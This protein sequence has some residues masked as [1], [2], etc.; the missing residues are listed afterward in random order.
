MGPI[1]PMLAPYKVRA[2][3]EKEEIEREENAKCMLIS[4]AKQLLFKNVMG[5]TH[6][7]E[8]SGDMLPDAV[9][10]VSS[11]AYCRLELASAMI[12]MILDRKRVHTSL[13]ERYL[14]EQCNGALIAHC[15]FCISFLCLKDH[16]ISV[17]NRGSCEN[18]VHLAILAV[19]HINDFIASTLMNYFE[20]VNHDVYS[21]VSA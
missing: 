3:W 7:V 18:I 6:R 11:V 5:A 14:S 2:D 9:R 15:C 20:T 17:T 16:S 21:V 4:H 13:S 19:K 10:V 1:E 12:F 8:P